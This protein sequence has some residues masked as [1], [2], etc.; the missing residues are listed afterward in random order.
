MGFKMLKRTNS[1]IRNIGRS[2]SRRLSY[3]DRARESS[4]IDSSDANSQEQIRRN[5]IQIGSALRQ[6]G[7]ELNNSRSS[8]NG[9]RLSLNLQNT[10]GN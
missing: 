1:R 2:L 5:S 7:D 10:S 9:S 6:I 3:R 8:L 4:P